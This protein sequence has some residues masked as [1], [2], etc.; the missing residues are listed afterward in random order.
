MLK[1][2]IYKRSAPHLATRVLLSLTLFFEMSPS[3]KRKLLLEVPVLIWVE[4]LHFTPNHATTS[5]S[6]H[7]RTVPRASLSCKNIRN[8]QFENNHSIVMIESWN[9]M[10]AGLR[11]SKGLLSML[12][13]GLK[14]SMS[15]GMPITPVA[16]MH[17]VAILLPAKNSS[18]W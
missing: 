5:S 10:P 13:G 4:L 18:H 16:V 6:L 7:S 14:S 12:R 1:T 11:R 17:R 2:C 8:L 15:S 9:A 3:G